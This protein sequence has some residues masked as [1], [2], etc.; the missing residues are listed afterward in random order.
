MSIY[1]E[2][3]SN[4]RSYCRDFPV[5]IEKA[6]GSYVYTKDGE[7]YLD[8]LAGAGALNFGHNNEEIV[9]PI[10][11]YLQNNGIIHALDLNTTAKTDFLETFNEKILKPRELDYKVMFCGPTGTNAVEAAIKL[12]RKVTGRDTVFAFFGSFHGM[13]TGSLAVSSK[14]SIKENLGSAGNFSRFFPYSDQYGF[15]SV[16]YIEKVLEDEYSGYEL[17]A[18][19]ILETVQAEGGVNI[20]SEEFLKKLEKLCKKY[21]ILLIVDEIQA[22][23]G[24]TGNYFSFERAGIKPD[25]VTVSKSISGAGLPMSLLLINSE[26]DIYRPGEHNG[27]FR[28]NQLAFVGAKAALDYLEENSL[29]E[30]VQEDE[31]YIKESFQELL[32][33]FPDIDYRGIG[34]IHGLD[35]NKFVDKTIAKQI[36]DECFKNNLIIENAG[37]NGNVL[38]LLPPLTISRNELEDGLKIIKDSVRKVL[39]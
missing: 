20:A 5:E 30:K 4:V 36:L 16:D 25:L 2:V 28:G 17:P 7:Q 38:K 10:I 39:K 33:E 13:T 12:A 29:L 11:D 9:S 24:R 27:T 21:G 22:G 1:D 31:K 26:D 14:K 34:L 35:F 23:I 37:P 3:E 8:F 6:K 15:D 18:A 19:I 32:E